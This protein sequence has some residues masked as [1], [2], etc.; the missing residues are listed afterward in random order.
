[1]PSLLPSLSRESPTGHLGFGA[2]E[3][4][5]EDFNVAGLRKLAQNLLHGRR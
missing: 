2:S 1:M 5:S 4:P 3:S